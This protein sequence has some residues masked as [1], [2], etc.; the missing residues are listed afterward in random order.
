[1]P[2]NRFCGSPEH[3]ISRRGFL[4]TVGAAAGAAAFADMTGIQAL[5]SPSVAG[6]LG[7]EDSRVPD[8]VSFYFATEGRGMAPGHPGFLG[9]RYGSM[10]LYT[11]NIPE[12]I[13]L[14]GISAQEHQE[15]GQLRDLLSSSFEQNRAGNGIDSHRQAYERVQGIMA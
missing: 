3:V 1:M 13:R 8:N 4:R 15:R 12:N 7:H 11:S 5:G 6:E 14:A 2:A 10:D 9:A